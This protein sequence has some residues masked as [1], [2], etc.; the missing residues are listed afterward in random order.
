ML[1]LN[2]TA[3]P[4]VDVVKTLSDEYGVTKQAFYHDWKKR[5]E[6]QT[7]IF[8]LDDLKQLCLD[9][10]ANH[11]EIY[12][13]A[14]REYLTGDNSSARVGA[15]NLLRKLNLDFLEMFP[16]A[17]ARHTMPESK[18]GADLNGL[19]K[20]YD[21]L[22]TETEKPTMDIKLSWQTVPSLTPEEMGQYTE[23]EK[24]TV[25]V[26][27]RLIHKVLDKRRTQSRRV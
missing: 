26:G 9:I 13:M 14:S 17:L 12:R 3:L 24:E 21:R 6:W 25:Q 5:G 27:T 8:D 4:F 18:R 16:K 7:E 2:S 19:L 23:E 20:E 10:Y 22:F 11:R 1:K 15:L